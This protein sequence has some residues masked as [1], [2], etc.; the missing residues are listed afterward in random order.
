ML[1]VNIE[2]AMKDMDQLINEVNDSQTPV[3]IINDQGKNAVLVSED[4]WKLIQE[5]IHRNKVKQNNVVIG[6]TSHSVE[7]RGYFYT[8]KRVA[9]V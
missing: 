5:E 2:N 9:P 4:E 1:T 6:I 3:L 8:I 7:C